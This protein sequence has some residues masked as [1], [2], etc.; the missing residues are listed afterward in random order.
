M[1]DFKVVCCRFVI[2]VCFFTETKVQVEVKAK[3]EV[4]KKEEEES[5]DEDESEEEEESDSEE[6]SESESESDEEDLTPY[7]RAEIK[8][9]VQLCVNRALGT[10]I[11]GSNLRI[12][13]L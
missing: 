10:H 12:H 8:I 6:E 7:E 9:K 5:E 3:E 4:Q 13:A 1:I 11:E 2:S